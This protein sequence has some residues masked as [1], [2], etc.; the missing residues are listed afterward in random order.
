MSC[1]HLKQKQK[2]K[3]YVEL[4]AYKVVMVTLNTVSKKWWLMREFLKQYL[5]EKQNGLLTKW[6]L[7]GSGCSQEV[8]TMRELT[9]QV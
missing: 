4:L 1:G 2:T 7:R 8:V 3:E 6:L 9:V 5:T